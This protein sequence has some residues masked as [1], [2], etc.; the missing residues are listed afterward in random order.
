MNAYITGTTIKNL[1][2]KQG[3]T[4][5][6][7][8][9][10]IGVTDKTVSKW[11]NGKGYPDISLLEPIA[12]I[13]GISTLELL[14]GNPIQNTNVSGN[15]LRSQLYVCPVCG[16]ILHSM[17]PAVISCHGIM[18][19]PLEPDEPDREHAPSLENAE[20][21]VYVSFKHPMSKSHYISF[22]AAVNSDRLIVIKLY[23]EG[24][25]AVRFPQRGLMKIYF[26]C[27]KDGLFSYNVPR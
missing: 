20:D 4:Q 18:L 13:F 10:L 16:N 5:A 21:E 24:E 14:Q 2:T 19:P 15:M 17:G 22:I 8:A 23:P 12:R 9:G 1:R 27:N 7:L 11:E 3:L 6:E 25:A 26:Y